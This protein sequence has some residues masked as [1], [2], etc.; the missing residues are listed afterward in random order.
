MFKKLSAILL[1]L[2]LVVS[3]PIVAFAKSQD[4][5]TLVETVSDHEALYNKINSYD[6]GD[7]LY[8]EAEPNDYMN[9]A[10]KIYSD[11]TIAGYI[12]SS[13]LDL[14]Y[15]SVSKKANILIVLAS[16][17]PGVAGAVFDSNGQKLIDIQREYYDG[18][19]FSILEG[20][21][22]AGGYYIGVGPTSS[23]T[24]TDEVYILYLQY[25]EIC[26]HSYSNACDNTC[27]DCGEARDVTHSYSNNCD[28]ECNVCFAKRV[29]PHSYSNACDTSCNACGETRNASHTY[30]NA[31]DTSCNVCGTTRTAPHSYSNESDTSCDLCGHTREVNRYK[32]SLNETKRIKW[33]GPSTAF[34]EF[35]PAQSGFYNF[36]IL[37]HSRTNKLF[38]E[39]ADLTTGE[40]VGFFFEKIDE[41]GYVSKDYLLAKGHKYELAIYYSGDDITV[42]PSADISISVTASSFV[43]ANMYNGSVTDSTTIADFSDKTEEW[44]RYTTTQKGDYDFYFTNDLEA[45]VCVYERSSGELVDARTTTY[46][47]SNYQ[48]ERPC[49]KLVYSLKANTEYY[50][51]VEEYAGK[52]AKLSMKKSATD[53]SNVTI[54]KQALTITGETDPSLVD[55]SV[56]NYNISYLGGGKTVMDYEAATKAGI[57]MPTVEYIGKTAMV[58]IWE[59]LVA[60]GQPVLVTYKD[61]MYVDYIVVTPITALLSDLRSLRTNEKVSIEFENYEESTFYYRVNFSKT[62]IYNL[63]LD[64]NFANQFQYYTITL[65]DQSNNVVNSITKNG[66]EWPIVAGKEYALMVRYCFDYDCNQSIVPQFYFQQNSRAIYPDTSTNG[67]Y[68]DAVNYV[69]GRGI[70][71]GYA[72]GKF[73]TSDGIQRQDFLVMLAR[74]DGVNLD[75]Y[76]YKS[77]F[78]D[79]SSGSYYEAA[80]NWGAE[81][82]IV[83]GYQNGEFGVGDKITREQ[84]VTFLYRYANYCNRDMTVRSSTATNAARQYKDFGKV[85]GFAKDAMIWALENGVISGKTSSTI[86]PHG[87]AQRCEVAKIMY[88]IFANYVF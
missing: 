61:Q 81:N 30:S 55:A 48:M 15:F 70:M 25:S 23:A 84:I 57:I 4:A 79:V 13:D 56:F 46:Y 85:S 49:D 41:S 26:T 65:I 8:N 67:W 37:D 68:Y 21:V 40:S 59:W 76:K 82:N 12:N 47:N 71:S 20:S 50:I 19:Y 6:L 7:N 38:V 18:L 35:S 43:P 39:I 87:N 58:D 33:T 29:A 69:T 60:G 3:A 52:T 51:F 63:V 80:V 22:E 54:N 16:Q 42:Q 28:D 78:P 83:T 88:N 34:V 75:D 24:S 53:V 2:L 31:C 17:T 86:V 27:N 77:K 62:G 74:L 5:V 72:N 9:N 36:N 66:Y 10:N 32:L 64:K 11:Y 44:Y 45:V 14:F 1:A 73:G